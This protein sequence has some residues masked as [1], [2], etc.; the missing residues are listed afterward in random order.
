MIDVIYAFTKAAVLPPLLPMLI[1]LAG[2]IVAR[3]R[4]RPGLAVAALGLGL[5]YLLASP[6]VSTFLN[7]VVE[8]PPVTN[9]PDWATADAIVVLSA[10]SESDSAE[11]GGETVDAASLVR[12][13]YAAALHR[14][15]GLPI[16]VSGGVMPA[17][18]MSL[19]A[20]MKASLETDFMVPVRWAETR[21][22]TT[23]ENA[24]FSAEMLKADGMRKIVLV[25]EAYHMRRSV[26]TFA[27][28]GLDVIAAPTVTRAGLTWRPTTVL[29]ESGAL[30]DSYVA[31]HEMIGL[32]WY[33]IKGR[34]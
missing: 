3:H 11:Y 12:L 23:A 15:T 10:G 33:W 16:M 20:L 5:L 1:L 32:V 8:L 17:R 18:R 7:R 4:V 19:A 25:T 30:V 26:A 13:R 22:T 27:A 2:L 34:I 31:I 9:N 21:S 14:R 24:A 28:Q 6:A 29:P